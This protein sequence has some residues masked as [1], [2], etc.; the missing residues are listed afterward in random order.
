M[1]SVQ[2]TLGD[3]MIQFLPSRRFQTGKGIKS[4]RTMTQSTVRELR[5]RKR[6]ENLRKVYQ[7]RP[8]WGKMGRNGKGTQ[9]TFRKTIMGYLSSAR[10]EL[11]TFHKF[12]S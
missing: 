1:S 5:R 4:M 6:R 10:M 2:E 8:R 9:T 12:I 3:G 7:G 11:R